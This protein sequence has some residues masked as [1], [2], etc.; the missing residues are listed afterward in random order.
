MYRNYFKRVLDFILS[1][2]GILLLLPFF[3]I[4][5]FVI[6][7]TSKGPVIF[8][9]ERVGRNK[10]LFTI[11]KFRTMRIN[12]P[13]DCPTHLL[14]NAESYIT[15]IGKFLR[16]TSLDE[17]P[18]LWNIF[19]GDMAIIGPR[20][21]L[22]SQIDLNELRDLNGASLVRPGLTG[23]AQINGRDE[24][25]ILKKAQLDGLYSNGVSFLGDIKIFIST[26]FSVIKFSGV[27]EGGGK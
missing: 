23:L 1:G 10:S 21:S 8:K 26:I 3:I 2:I 11:Y 22:V 4:I 12:T 13:S 20:P 5:A 14:N 6:K 25:P 9:Q 15:K 17:I 19:I 18:Q 24:L 27:Q 7:L 16:K